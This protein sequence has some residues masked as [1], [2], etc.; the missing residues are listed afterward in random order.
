MTE[1]GVLFMQAVDALDD[2]FH[3]HADTAG[4]VQLLLLGVRQEFVERRI[5]KADRGGVALKSFEDAGEVLALVGQK[6]REGRTAAFAVRGE[7]HL[8][9]GVDSFSLEEHMLG[10]GEPDTGRAEG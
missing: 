4:E 8:A 3:L 1:H 5:E 7:D 9:H 6:L 2:A 10:A